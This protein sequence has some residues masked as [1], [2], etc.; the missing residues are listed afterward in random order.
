MRYSIQ[1]KNRLQIALR[2]AIC[3]LENALGAGHIDR[4]R[5]LLTIDDFKADD[6]AFLEFL[7]H[8]T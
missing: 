1:T 3:S 4:S 8:D 5:A 6:I 2:A 7:E